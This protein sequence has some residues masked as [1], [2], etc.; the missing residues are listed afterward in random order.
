MLHCCRLMTH[1]MLFP[2]ACYITWCTIMWGGT[3]D[4]S[5]C[6]DKWHHCQGNPDLN[7]LSNITCC[8]PCFTPAL[9]KQSCGFCQKFS[10]LSASQWRHIPREK[11]Y[12]KQGH[13]MLQS[14][15]W[16]QVCDVITA[17]KSARIKGRQSSYLAAWVTGNQRGIVSMTSC[18]V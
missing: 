13:V 7:Q 6:L 1:F 17:V 8:A 14:C 3:R 11:S 15:D 18:W 2:G 12:V 5:T 9:S 4:M 16:Q 10:V